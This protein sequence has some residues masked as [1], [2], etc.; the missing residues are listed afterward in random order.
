MEGRGLVG[1]VVVQA[2]SFRLLTMETRTI[3][4]A[5]FA[6]DEV[7]LGHYF[8]QTRPGYLFNIIP[9]MHHTNAPT[10]CSFYLNTTLIC[11]TSGLSLGA[12][13]QRSP[14]SGG[15]HGT[16]K[17]LYVLLGNVCR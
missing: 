16:E 17:Y 10:L 9:P 4:R 12:L 15:Q 1:P 14:A 8:L 11:R 5:R 3:L 2:F 6:V 13:K 7:T